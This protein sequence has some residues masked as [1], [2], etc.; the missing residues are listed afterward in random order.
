MMDRTLENIARQLSES[1]IQELLR[2]KK[3]EDKKMADLRARR[4]K[5]AEEIAEIDEMLAGN[6]EE[7][8]PK[9]RRGRRPAATTQNTARTP[10]AAKTVA[11]AQAKQPGRRGGPRLRAGKVN[12]AAAVREVFQRAGEPLRARQ[13]VEGLPEAGVKVPDVLEMRKR[14][15]VILAQHK[16]SFE[17][18]ERGIYRLKEA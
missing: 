11:P 18:V 17:Q 16:N 1:D 14:V 2:I 4:D 13:V 5:L 6:A 12:M 9:A 10:R 8:A 3:S 7:D 15:S